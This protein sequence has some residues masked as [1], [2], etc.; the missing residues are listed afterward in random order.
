M[1]TTPSPDRGQVLERRVREVPEAGLLNDADTVPFKSESIMGLYDQIRT[2][3]LHFPAHIN[4]SESLK[5]LI[6][7]L[8]C[9]DPELRI[10]L[11]A[12]LAHPW[13]THNGEYPLPI[14]QVTLCCHHSYPGGEG[15][16]TSWKSMGQP[17]QELPPVELAGQRMHLPF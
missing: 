15:G 3:P 8:L 2:A 11:P 12:T 14:M 16:V 5:H 10:C 9:K 6:G 7:R 17:Q 1:P 13:V 4:A